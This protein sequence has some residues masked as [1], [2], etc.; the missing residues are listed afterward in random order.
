VDRGAKIIVHRRAQH[1]ILLWFDNFPTSTKQPILLDKKKDFYSN[2]KGDTHSTQ[3]SF[4]SLNLS[5]QATVERAFIY[6][7]PVMFWI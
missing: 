1:N 2:E 4:L 6:R 7:L 5:L 3:L